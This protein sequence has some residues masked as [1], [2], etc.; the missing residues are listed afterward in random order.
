MRG[1]TGFTLVELMIVATVVSIIAG[2]AVPNLLSSRAV[3]NERAVVASLRTLATVQ[4]QAVTRV[5]VD[6]DH[7]GVGEP[8]GLDQLS[9]LR[10]LPDGL[11]LE[12]PYLPQSM[13]TLGAN[14]LCQ[15]RGYLLAMYLPDT[16]GVG[17]LA[18]AANAGNVDADGAELAWSCLAWPVARGRTGTA[19][20]FVNQTGEI[21][22][23]R[24]ATYDGPSQ[25]P[26]A[27]AA[28]LGGAADELGG[29]LALD[30][31]GADGNLWRPLR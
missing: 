1:Q 24:G 25:V 2:I 3:A 7:D 18:T 23:A 29:Q 5:V 31:P 27:G 6:T 28:L 17:Q 19:T 4:T 11:M 26:P 9:G 15:S 10:M 22:V 8:I 14:G 30:V 13:G 12:P 20:F 21:L 16:S